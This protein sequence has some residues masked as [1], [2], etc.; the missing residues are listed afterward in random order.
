MMTRGLTGDAGRARHRERAAVTWP[1]HR[2]ARV[3]HLAAASAIGRP[4]VVAPGSRGGCA[5]GPTPAI[6]LRPGRGR[7]VPDEAASRREAA[8]RRLD[9]LRG[10]R[11]RP[12]HIEDH[13]RGD[14]IPHGPSGGPRS[15]CA[16]VGRRR[17]ARSAIVPP[18]VIPAAPAG[19]T[20]ADE[21]AE[22]AQNKC[23]FTLLSRSVLEVEMCKCFAVVNALRF[24][25]VTPRGPVCRDTSLKQCQE[26]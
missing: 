9:G 3:E 1:V 19:D 15:V 17:P 18:Y 21:V 2:Q 11:H 24:P 14:L 20:D 22:L 8:G 6:A 23:L 5:A 26:T 4:R 25:V 10:V 13:N 12:R 7:P 16:L